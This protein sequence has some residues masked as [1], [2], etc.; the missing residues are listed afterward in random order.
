MRL[1]RDGSDQ[2]C[3]TVLSTQLCFYILRATGKVLGEEGQAVICLLCSGI[4]TCDF[5]ETGSLI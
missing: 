2:S 5:H 4:P 1:T 3:V